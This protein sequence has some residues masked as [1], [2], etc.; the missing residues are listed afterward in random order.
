MNSES[1]NSESRN[2]PLGASFNEKFGRFKASIQ[3]GCA[4]G[5]LGLHLHEPSNDPARFA[6][7]SDRVHALFASESLRTLDTLSLL[8]SKASKN[9]RS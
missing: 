4:K 1:R 7:D 3:P 8:A 6:I 2:T 9:R 5:K